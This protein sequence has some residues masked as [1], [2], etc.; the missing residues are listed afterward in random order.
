M[1]LLGRQKEERAGF[2]TIEQVLYRGANV[3]YIAN[4]RTTQQFPNTEQ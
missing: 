1:L 4:K 2:K 3:V